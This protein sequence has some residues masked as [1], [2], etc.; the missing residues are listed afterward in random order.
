M[1]IYKT[2]KPLQVFST[3]K[4]ISYCVTMAMRYTCDI[5]EKVFKNKNGLK[6]HYNIKHDIGALQPKACNICD[7]TL[8]G[9]LTLHI[10]N[11]HGKKKIHKCDSCSKYFSTL[12]SLKIHIKRVHEANFKNKTMIHIFFLLLVKQPIY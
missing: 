6:T 3:L 11:V 5:C 9:S 8:I 4:L 12:G 1:T 10:N 7:K 2:I